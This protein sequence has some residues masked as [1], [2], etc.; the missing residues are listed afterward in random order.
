MNICI[1]IYI[2]T[3]VYIRVYIHRI[4]L[5]SRRTVKA[6]ALTMLESVVAGDWTKSMEV[7]LI[8]APGNAKKAE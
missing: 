5:L 8:L 1:Y 3:Y 6:A 2:Y 4:K 7:T